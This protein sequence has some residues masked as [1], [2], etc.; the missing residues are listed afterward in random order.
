[1]FLAAVSTLI[2]AIVG[3]YVRVNAVEENAVVSCLWLRVHLYQQA[4]LL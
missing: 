2:G 3:V 4:T 1:M